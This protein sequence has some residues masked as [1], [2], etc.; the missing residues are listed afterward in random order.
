MTLFAPDKTKV[1]SP[2]LAETSKPGPYAVLA[3]GSAWE[4]KKWY[5]QGFARLSTLLDTMGV[6]VLLIGGPDETDTCREIADKGSAV[7][8]SGRLSLPETYFLMSRSQ[9]I[10]TN[11][12][13]AMHMASAAKRPTVAVFCSTVPEFGFGPW[14]NPFSIIVEQRGLDCRPCGDHGHRACPNGT[15]ACMRTDPEKVLDGCRQVLTMWD[16]RHE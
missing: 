13:M 9:L 11:D 4:T 8:F 2:V 10:V 15:E 7:D 6:R 1:S 5:W 3:P 16:G 14:Q 12:S